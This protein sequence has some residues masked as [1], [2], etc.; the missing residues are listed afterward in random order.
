M[1]STDN[2]TTTAPA[3]PTVQPPLMLPLYGGL[4]KADIVLAEDP[5]ADVRMLQV[6]GIPCGHQ[7]VLLCRRSDCDCLWLVVCAE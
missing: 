3:V 2:K 6:M 7:D 1:S 5:R 4:G